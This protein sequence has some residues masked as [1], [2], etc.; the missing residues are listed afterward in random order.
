[1]KS[2]RKPNAFNGELT[3]M[4]CQ[5]RDAITKHVTPKAQSGSWWTQAEGGEA[6]TAIA[7]PEQ[8]RMTNVDSAP[9]PDL[10]TPREA[11]A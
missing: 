4:A 11:R 3:I 9:R 6:F 7:Q 8:A 2:Q 1:M 10:P 5:R